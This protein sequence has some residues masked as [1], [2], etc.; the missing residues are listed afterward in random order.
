MINSSKNGSRRTG[1]WLAMTAVLVVVGWRL[2]VIAG[3]QHLLA[4]ATEVGSIAQFRGELFSNGAGTSLV[5]SRETE[6]GIGTF[7]CETASGKS[8][9]LFE[10]KENGYSSQSRML[11]WSPDDRIFACAV[12][13]DSNPMHPKSAIILYNGDSGEPAAKIESDGFLWLT[14]FIWLSPHSFA[15]QTYNQAWVVF[16]QKSDDNWVQ[17]RVI[18]KFADG[19]LKNLTVTSPHSF[20]WQQS[21]DV[22]TYDLVSEASE[23]I[24]GSA[25]NHLDGFGYSEETGNFLLNCHDENGPL[26]ICFHPPRLWDKQGAILDVTR[27]DTRTRYADLRIDHGR[28]SFSI[29]TS[30]NSETTHFVW[31]RNPRYLAIRHL[32]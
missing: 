7:F 6:T 28:Y 11:D 22:W 32:L 24:W 5:F 14:K 18:K 3:Q 2:C 15:Y 8:K 4:I 17:T 10:Q 12:L 30:A 13:L 20:A 31:K 16:E 1:F 19:E 21:D 29:K 9:L 27:S 26:S 23:K 25:S